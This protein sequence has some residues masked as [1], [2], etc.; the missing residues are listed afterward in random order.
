MSTYK[1]FLA[2]IDHP[3]CEPIFR[4]LFEE[5]EPVIWF[6]FKGNLNNFVP[7]NHPHYDVECEKS[8]SGYV[9]DHTKYTELNY[10]ESWGMGS[11][12]FEYEYWEEIK[13]Y[14]KKNGPLIRIDHHILKPALDRMLKYSPSDSYPK[15]KFA[16]GDYTLRE[17]YGWMLD[18]Y[19][20]YC[21]HYVY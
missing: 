15:G 16:A 5:Q 9:Y 2:A 21:Y 1:Y 14:F 11:D 7:E 12:P 8:I 20:R 10:F 19:D 18:N 17:I 3:L 13:D 6:E 4:N